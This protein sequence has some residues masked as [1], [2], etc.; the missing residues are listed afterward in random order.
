MHQ[1]RV[2]VGLRQDFE[3]EQRHR[4]ADQVT[5]AHIAVQLCQDGERR[6]I[7]NAFG[8]NFQ[9][10]IVRK[11]DCSFRTG[12]NTVSEASTALPL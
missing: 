8:D 9:A 10:Q 2:R 12:S 1:R 7:L 6:F 11:F 4:L 5:L 3:I